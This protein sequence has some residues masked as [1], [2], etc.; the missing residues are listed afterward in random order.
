MRNARKKEWSDWIRLNDALGWLD[1]MSNAP[2]G[3]LNQQ[4]VE[5][6]KKMA[7]SAAEALKNAADGRGLILR[8]KAANQIEAALSTPADG[9]HPRNIGMWGTIKCAFKEAMWY[10]EPVEEG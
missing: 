6:K 9:L 1:A 10:P 8:S 3:D 5:M 4:G 2:T 7:A